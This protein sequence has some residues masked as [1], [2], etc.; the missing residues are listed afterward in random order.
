[1]NKE[2][3]AGKNDVVELLNQINS[4]LIAAEMAMEEAGGVLAGFGA[5]NAGQAAAEVMA[6]MDPS[7]TKEAFYAVAKEI[8]ALQ[9]SVLKSRNLIAAAAGRMNGMAALNGVAD[10]GMQG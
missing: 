10:R 5:T 7:A 1:M 8:D 6:H 9:L 2:N 3:N 4:S